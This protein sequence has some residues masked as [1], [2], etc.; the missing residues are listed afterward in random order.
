MLP[1]PP[2]DTHMPNRLHAV[3]VL[4]EDVVVGEGVVGDEGW[5][6]EVGRGDDTGAVSIPVPDAHTIQ[7]CTTGAELRPSILIPATLLSNR[8]FPRRTPRPPFEK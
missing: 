7:S 3:D 2:S 1:P 6:E 5:S 8:T 4:W